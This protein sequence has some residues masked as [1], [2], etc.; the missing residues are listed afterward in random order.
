[1]TGEDSGGGVIGPA[2]RGALVCMQHRGTVYTASQQEA[3]LL[4]NPVEQQPSQV[5]SPSKH[6]QSLA[7]QFTHVPIVAA[8]SAYG[9]GNHGGGNTGLDVPGN[10]GAAESSGKPMRGGEVAAQHRAA[11]YTESQ[12][13]D[14]S[15]ARPVAQHPAHLYFLS[16]Q[17]ASLAQTDDDLTKARKPERSTVPSAVNMTSTVL[18]GTTTPS[19]R[20]APENDRKMGPLVLFPMYTLT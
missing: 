15:S 14:A 6:L 12:H 4:L 9:G 19:G 13:E 7:Q 3:P 17:D 8:L 5:Y 18:D 20:T 16:K 1:M 11:V 2:V 10:N